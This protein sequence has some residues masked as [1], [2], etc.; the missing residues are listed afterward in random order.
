MLDAGKSQKE[1]AQVFGVTEGAISKTKK[2]LNI[3][4]V[5]NVVLENA[6]QVVSKKLDTIDQLTKINRRANEILDALTECRIDQKL[7]A[8]FSLLSTSFGSEQ[9]IRTRVQGMVKEIFGDQTVALRACAEIRQQLELQLEV[10]RTLYDLQE[11]E[12][13]Q[14]EVLDAIESVSPELRKTIV[15]RLKER[16]ALR[17]S[18]IF[19]GS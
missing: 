14:K 13:F 9:E 8:I 17:P 19:S 5:K 6:H 2:E 4:V 3:N 18:A 7:D 1:V 12:S 16:R 11:V 15:R 10:F